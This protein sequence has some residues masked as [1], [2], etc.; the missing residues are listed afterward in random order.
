ME[1]LFGRMNGTLLDG[2]VRRAGAAFA[3]GSFSPEFVMT[4]ASEACTTLCP[5]VDHPKVQDYVHPIGPT[6]CGHGSGKSF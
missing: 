6:R 5:S 1:T 2:G 4:D 3:A